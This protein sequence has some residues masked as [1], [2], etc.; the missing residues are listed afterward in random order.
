MRT[1]RCSDNGSVHRGQSPDLVWFSQGSVQGQVT[2]SIYCDRQAWQVPGPVTTPA[3][4]TSNSPA[5]PNPAKIALPTKA[6]YTV[7][8]RAESRDALLHRR[9]SGS[10]EEKAGAGT[11]TRILRSSGL[12]SPRVHNVV[13][14]LPVGSYLFLWGPAPCHSSCS[15]HRTL[16]KSFPRTGALLPRN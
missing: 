8:C 7:P 4:T 2:S 6:A 10:P 13:L 9:A 14:A 15:R 3:T 16:S 12:H 1:S 5:T 11:N